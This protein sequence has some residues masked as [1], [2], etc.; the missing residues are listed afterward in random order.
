[1][2]RSAQHDNTHCQLSILNCPFSKRRAALTAVLLLVAVVAGGGGCRRLADEERV[3]HDGRARLL[4][5]RLPVGSQL[6]AEGHFPLRL[7]RGR[8]GHHEAH[9]RRGVGREQRGG[10]EDG[11]A[12]RAVHAAQRHADVLARAAHLHVPIVAEFLERRRLL[13][14]RDEIFGIIGYCC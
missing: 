13:A 5:Q 11:L 9:A 3:R 7:V 1:M 10:D 12:R 6:R 2:L 4:E 8:G 14:D